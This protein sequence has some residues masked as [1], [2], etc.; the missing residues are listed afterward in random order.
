MKGAVSIFFLVSLLVLNSCNQPRREKSGNAPENAEQKDQQRDARFAAMVY[1]TNLL[2]IELGK[3]AQRNSASPEVQKFAQL[4][5]DGHTKDNEELKV[6]AQQKS[7][8]LPDTLSERGKRKFERLSEAK[9]EEFDRKYIR[10]M[11]RE[12]KDAIDAFEQQVEQG[13]DDVMKIW[14]SETIPTI[15]HHLEMAEATEEILRKNRR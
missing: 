9:A 8:R 13:H 4:M 14:A 15:R 10:F 11:I 5:V 6:V 12:H 2:E 7:I 3:V 1:E